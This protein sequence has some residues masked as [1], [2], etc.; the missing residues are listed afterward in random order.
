MD[1][2]LA[3]ESRG[4]L[5]QKMS[6]TGSSPNNSLKLKLEQANARIKKLKDALK[7]AKK[8]IKAE[9]KAL[10][11][12]LKNTRHLNRLRE[13]M[14]MLKSKKVNLQKQRKAD[15][16]SHAIWRTQH[17]QLVKQ[18]NKKVRQKSISVRQTKLKTEN[19]KK[20][21]KEKTEKNAS[22]TRQLRQVRKEK[23]RRTTK[24]APH[25]TRRIQVLTRKL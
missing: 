16:K 3:E 13:E 4:K 21:L 14:A 15:N 5:E 6:G 12:E 17:Q 18:L 8:D 22:L 2:K 9:K 10:E 24:S 1:L 25:L 11:K 23:L 20:T 7:R 19:I